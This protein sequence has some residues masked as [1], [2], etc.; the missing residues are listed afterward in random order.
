MKGNAD[1]ITGLEEQPGQ[2]AIAA[3]QDPPATTATPA[4]TTTPETS[5]TTG[6]EVPREVTATG[7]AAVSDDAKGSPAIVA[8][9]A[10]PVAG[11]DSEVF[12]ADAQVVPSTANADDGT[13]DVVWYSGAPVPRIDRSTGEPYMLRLAMEGCRMDRLNSGAPVFDT[14]FTGDDFKSLMA[15]KVGTRAQVGVV[16]RAWP[17]GPKGMATLKFDMGDPDGAEMFRKASTGILQNLSFGTFIYKREKTDM[18]TE[19]MAE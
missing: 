2:A 17:N 11:R 8:T 19:G 7:D 14:H 12:A 16:Q 9:T 3:A 10:A 15:G 4:A 6:T 5:T 1:V 18:Q 13:I